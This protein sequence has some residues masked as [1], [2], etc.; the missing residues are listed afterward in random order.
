ME[1]DG[2]ER[3]YRKRCKRYNVP[4]HTHYLTFSCFKRQPFLNRDRS[5]VWFL[6]AFRRALVLHDF[7]LY[8]WVIMP[9]HAHVLVHPRRREYSISKFLRSIKQPVS[10]AAIRYVRVH[11]PLF[12]DKM[13]DAQPNGTFNYRFWQR[14]G[15]YDSNLWTGKYIMEK[16]RYTH[17]NPVR[18]KLVRTPEEWE[19]SSARDYARLRAEP[20]LPLDREAIAWFW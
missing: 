14:G 11:A 15:G 9:E 13:L 8:A 17:M 16:I 7:A 18:R 2:R 3:V 5:R 4:G 20:L 6:D 19:W 10:H 12:L 1:M